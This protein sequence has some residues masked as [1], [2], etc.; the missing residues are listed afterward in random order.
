MKELI[1]ILSLIALIFYTLVIINICRKYYLKRKYKKIYLA[2]LSVGDKVIVK[3]ISMI[4]LA[5]LLGYN[6]LIIERVESK[7]FYLQD[8]FKTTKFVI[9]KKDIEFEPDGRAYVTNP[10]K[11][12][13]IRSTK[14][15]RNVD[16]SLNSR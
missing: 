4:S 12:I 10:R 1:L 8:N 5:G 15:E 2:L 11:L 16:F 14:E 7:E 6:Y 3:D 13:Y 9:N